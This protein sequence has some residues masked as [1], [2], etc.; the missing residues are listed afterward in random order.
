MFLIL[1]HTPWGLTIMWRGEDRVQ[2]HMI[3]STYYPRPGFLLV[4]VLNENA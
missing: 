2:A 3:K 1:H 4:E